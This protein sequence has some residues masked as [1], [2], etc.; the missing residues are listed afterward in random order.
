[1]YLTELHSSPENRMT[2]CQLGGVGYKAVVSLELQELQLY[3][4]TRDLL[5]GLAGR[6]H[7]RPACTVYRSKD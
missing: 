4:M 5:Q 3:A 2:S 1:M 7:S 6:I